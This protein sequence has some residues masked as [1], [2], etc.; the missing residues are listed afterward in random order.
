ME[1]L[2]IMFLISCSK[3]DVSLIDLFID[4]DWRFIVFERELEE[5]GDFISY[6]RKDK[7]GKRFFLIVLYENIN[8]YFSYF[9]FKDRC[10]LGWF[11]YRLWLMLYL[12]E[13]IDNWKSLMILFLEKRKL[14]KD[15]FNCIMEISII[16]FLISCSK[17]NVFLVDLFIDCD[18]SS[19]EL[20]EFDPYCRI[21]YSYGLNIDPFVLL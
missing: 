14:E 6:F 9:L 16:M 2:I 21:S 5:F 11:F 17:I 18:W 7:V 12:R 13:D 20:E 8:N 1:I 19:R 4:C 3:I 15:F 10:L